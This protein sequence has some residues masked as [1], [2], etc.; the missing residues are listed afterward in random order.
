MTDLR[1][2]FTPLMFSGASIDFQTLPYRDRDHLPE[3]RKQYVGQ[4]AF[5]RRGELIYALP[6]V[7]DV[8]EIGTTGRASIDDLHLVRPLIEQ[9]LISFFAEKKRLA[10][11]YKPLSFVGRRLALGPEAFGEWIQAR[12]KLLV[13][14]R[15]LDLPGSKAMLGLVWDGEVE[16]RLPAPLSR[17]IELGLDPRGMVVE[18]ENVPTDVRFARWRRV[19]GR[20]SHLDGDFVVLGERYGDAPE[21]ISVDDVYLEPSPANVRHLTESLIRQQAGSLVH[22]FAKLV[23]DHSRGANKQKHIVEVSDWLRSAGPIT[24]QPGLAFDVGEL[25]NQKRQPFPQFRSVPAATYVFDSAC[26]KADS[27]NAAGLQ[28]FG[29]L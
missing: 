14:P 25:L 23:E 22:K 8:P 17:L 9:R 3:L 26:L 11:S 12:S 5:Q 24:L 1:L 4:F 27:R 13:A 15:Q 16:R 18:T 2:N 21:R 20:I 6:M 7:E 28:K 19:A 10:T 29:R